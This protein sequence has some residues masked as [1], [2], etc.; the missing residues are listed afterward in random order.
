MIKKRYQCFIVFA[1]IGLWPCVN[2]VWACGSLSNPCGLTVTYTVYPY[3]SNLTTGTP[4]YA[5]NYLSCYDP[6]TQQYLNCKFTFKITGLQD[7]AGH[8]HNDDTHPLGQLS[9]NGGS[10]ILQPSSLEI[11]GQ[12]ANTQVA[13][14]HTMPEASG[15]IGAEL[16]IYSPPGYSCGYPCYT[17]TSYR[18]VGTINVGVRGLEQM[19][20]SGNGYWR[21][22]GAYGQPDVKSLHFWNH[23]GTSSVTGALSLIAWRYFEET[24][25]SMGIN[26]MSLPK[27]GLFDIHNDWK[28]PHGM[29]V[30]TDNHRIGKAADIDRDGINCEDD[31]DLAEAV[32]FVNKYGYV[33]GGQPKAKLL[34]EHGIG[35]EGFK[36]ID[37]N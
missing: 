7:S 19:P 11:T 35:F 6:W 2:S 15:T 32:K 23:Y 20:E 13:I 26:D 30:G 5:K 33:S 31:A 24:E 22:T 17:E 4:S 16:F 9:A 18:A 14:T 21:L 37:F 28:S 25:R 12:T 36:H 8:Y 10:S 3:P 34:C 29:L 27:G 1:L